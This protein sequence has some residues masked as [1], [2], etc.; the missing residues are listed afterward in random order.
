V[1]PNYTPL[2]AHDVLRVPTNRPQPQRRTKIHGTC[3]TGWRGGENEERKAKKNV[4][5]KDVK[6]GKFPSEIGSIVSWYK[7]LVHYYSE[8]SWNYSEIS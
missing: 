2:E 6:C 8:I 4:E 7:V 5:K 3:G 1:L